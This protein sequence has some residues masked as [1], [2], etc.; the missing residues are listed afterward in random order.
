[1]L[2]VFSA[3]ARRCGVTTIRVEKKRNYVSIQNDVLCDARLSWKARGILAYLLSKPDD[4]QIRI[5]DLIKGGPDGKDAI[6]S[7][8]AELGSLGYL[9]KYTIKDEGG[10]FGGVAY[11]IHEDPIDPAASGFAANGSTAS[12]FSGSG[13][14]ASG[15]SATTNTD[16]DKGLIGI[17]TEDTARGEN[18]GKPAQRRDANEQAE[19]PSQPIGISKSPKPREGALPPPPP[20]TPIDLMRFVNAYPSHRSRCAPNELQ[21]AWKAATGKVSADVL[22][23]ALDRQ[24]RSRAWEEEPKYI[25]GILRWLDEERWN[26]PIEEP[27]KLR[28]GQPGYVHPKPQ[29]GIWGVDY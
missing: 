28:P 29:L 21:R 12:G 27:A 9:E 7:A 23:A 20:P 16:R 5:A 15:E 22:F 10:R 8:L 18:R 11:V 26:D 6:Y 19:T 24:K 3:C 1:V 25:V 2:V 14:S 4:W 17:K 13:S